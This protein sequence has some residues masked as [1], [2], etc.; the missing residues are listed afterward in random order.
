MIVRHLQRSREVQ[1]FRQVSTPRFGRHPIKTVLAVRLLLGWPQ[2]H[3]QSSSEESNWT[4]SSIALGN[5]RINA[6]IIV[7]GTG[8]TRDPDGMA[9]PLGLSHIALGIS[10]M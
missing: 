6:S 2:A 5:V 8:P 1:Q 7:A 10:R 3:M 4:R 9:D